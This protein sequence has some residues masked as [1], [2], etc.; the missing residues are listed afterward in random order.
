[1]TENEAKVKT[2]G[3]MLLCNNTAKAMVS[4]IA[5]FN[6]GA[7]QY[8]T[9]ADPSAIFDTLSICMDFLRGKKN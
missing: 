7:E 3:N 4:N 8:N 1:M 5:P 9:I 6:T 2:V